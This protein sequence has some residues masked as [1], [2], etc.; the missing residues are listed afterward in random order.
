MFGVICLLFVDLP[1]EL[2]IVI[3]VERSIAAHHHKD[4]MVQR[5]KMRNYFRWIEILRRIGFRQ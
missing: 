2:S 4:M 1:L 3:A 5:R